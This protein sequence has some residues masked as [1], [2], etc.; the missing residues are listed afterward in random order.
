MTAERWARIT[1]VFQ[2][3]LEKSAE[4]RAA[5]LDAAC[6]GDE[7]LRRNVERL[8]ATEA[9]PSLASPAREFVETGALE[10]DS[11]EM[12]AQY[13]VEAKI[14]EGGMGAVFRGYDTRLRRRVALKVLAPE[15]L[16]DRQWKRRLMREA[17]AA[18]A[19]NHPNIVTIYEVGSDREV[20]F[21]AME[22]VLGKRLDELIP[23]QGL[24]TT[25]LL[26]YAVQMADALAAAHGGG[27]LHRDLKPSNIMVTEEGRVKIM[28]FGLAKILEPP[29]GTPDVTSETM[30][31]PTLEGTIAG[32]PSYMSPEQAEG[33]QLDARSD[34]FSFG[35][36]LYEMATGRRP[37]AAQSYLALVHKI[38]N[39]DP[40][41]PSRLAPVPTELESLILV[42]LRK[43]KSRRYQSAA[44][45]KAALEALQTEASA[46]RPQASSPAFDPGR[47]RRQRAI[48]RAALISAAILGALGTAYVALRVFWH[49]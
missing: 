38:A 46:P 26:R 5:F 17:R 40:Q 19:L 45:L 33:R 18:S 8:L 43:D 47:S 15:R 10:L 13:R 11:G 6:A 1:E 22:C 49:P 12:L 37:F 28:D 25:Q 48:R 30:T 42:C 36:V 23:P 16:A 39:I 32:T 24:S 34:I 27:V 14:G 7:P 31:E 35:S 20:D 9:E 44:D 41:P 2:S 29:E 21:I 3:A 4:E